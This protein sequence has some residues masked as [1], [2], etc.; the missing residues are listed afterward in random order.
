MVALRVLK[1]LQVG[2]PLL[3]SSETIIDGGIA[4]Y[5]RTLSGILRVILVIRRRHE[6]IRG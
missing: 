3:C 6:E 5:S 4:L 2:L 1:N